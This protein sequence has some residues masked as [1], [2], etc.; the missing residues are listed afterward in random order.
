V[1]SSAALISRIDSVLNIDGRADDWGDFGLV[2]E[3]NRAGQ[4]LR[5]AGLWQ[6]P[7]VDSHSVRLAWDNDYLYVLAAVRDPEHEQNSTVSGVWQGDALWLYFTNAPSANA[8]SAKLTLAQTPNGTQV[9]D[10]QRS[11]FARGALLAWQRAEDGLGYT[12]EAALPW[13]VLN[14]D[15]PQPGAT[16]GFE[17]G[18][19]IGGNSFMDLTGRDPDV[20]ANLLQ[21]TLTAPDVSTQMGQAPRVALEVRV[22]DAP[23]YVLEQTVSPDSDYFWLDL[24]TPVPVW[25]EQ[26]EHLIR[27]EYA[28]EE[29][30]GGSSNPGLSKIDAFVLYPIIGRRL[31][32][33]PDGRD[34]VLTYDTLTGASDLRPIT[35]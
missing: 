16:L 27:Y 26:G 8:L 33:L 6:G 9:W 21:L 2:L 31:I 14:I 32:A 10:W 34:F 13:A 3:S 12:Y 25:L 28:G 11:R 29:T 18:R 20:A 22:D 1:D 5:G 17:A 7:D 35:P 19:G 4:F 15:T 24:V 23:G 30:S